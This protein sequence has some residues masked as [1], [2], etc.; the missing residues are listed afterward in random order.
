MWSF[1]T[2]NDPARTKRARFL[3]KW[4]TGDN[5]QPQ[6][7]KPDWSGFRDP[8]ALDGKLETSL[9]TTTRTARR[10]LLSVAAVGQ[11]PLCASDVATAFLQGKPQQRGVLEA[12]SR[13]REGG[14][15]GPPATR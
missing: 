12:T 9:P 2:E 4:R 6:V 11:W 14:R 1:A 5:G 13:R 7:P 10:I 8:D 15:S 3:L